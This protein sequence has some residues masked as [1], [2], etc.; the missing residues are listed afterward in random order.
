MQMTSTISDLKTELALTKDRL[1]LLENE[2]RSIENQSLSQNDKNL[3]TIK[4][5]EK[6]LEALN[7]E[8]QTLTTDFDKKF[9]H[10]SESNTKLIEKLKLEAQTEKEQLI[11]KYESKLNTEKTIFEEKLLTLERVSRIFNKLLTN[12]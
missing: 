8:K 1:D 10:L 7:N 4:S 3:N 5:L 12:T 9:S 6:Q 2:R 11:D